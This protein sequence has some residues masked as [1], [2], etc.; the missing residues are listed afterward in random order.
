MKYLDEFKKYLKNF[1][2]SI[3][4]GINVILLSIVYI[5]GVGFTSIFAKLLNK[6]FLELEFSKK[7]TY[8]LDLNLKKKKFEDYFKQS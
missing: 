7:N 8:W 2:H 3:N 1:Q 4:T 5:V 6:H